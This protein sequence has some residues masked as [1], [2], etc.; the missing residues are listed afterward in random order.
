[1]ENV[2]KIL[3]NNSPFLILLVG[4]PLSGKST[5]IETHIKKLKIDNINIISRDDI[6]Q[7]VTK[8]SNYDEAWE[9]MLSNPTIE[10]S[11][12][13]ELVNRL[14]KISDNKENC[15]IDMTNLTIKGRNKHLAKFHKHYKIAILFDFIDD[16]EYKL[17]ESNRNLNTNKTISLSVMNRMRDSYEEV[18]LD[19]DLDLII[20][21]KDLIL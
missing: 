21:L 8:C 9:I 14:I 12:H 2:K 6:I 10:K 7:E 17:R 15:V 13:T 20:N 11:I 19:E 1:M 3:N 16:I 4:T 5:F 18:T